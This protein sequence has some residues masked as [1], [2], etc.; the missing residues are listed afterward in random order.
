VDVNGHAGDA[1]LMDAV[2]ELETH[3]VFV[4]VLGTY[5]QTVAA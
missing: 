2:K 3:S 5:P 4:K 1:A